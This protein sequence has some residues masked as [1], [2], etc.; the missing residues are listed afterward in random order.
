MNS[1]PQ[2]PTSAAPVSN[3]QPQALTPEQQQARAQAKAE[4]KERKHERLR[5]FFGWCEGCRAFGEGF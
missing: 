3:S 4:K 5:F 2:S 1:H